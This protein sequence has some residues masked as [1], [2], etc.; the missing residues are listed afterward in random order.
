MCRERPEPKVY[1]NYTYRPKVNHLGIDLEANEG[2]PAFAAREGRIVKIN[3]GDISNQSIVIRHINEG[4]Q[5]FATRYQHLKEV[6]VTAGQ[7]IE[8]GD[9]LGFIGPIGHLHFEVH[10]IINTSASPNDWNR[11]NM[12]PIGPAPLLYPWEKVYFEQILRDRPRIDDLHPET[13]Q[14][15]GIV[16][17][18][19][20]PM[21]WL[22]QSSKI[23][24]IPLYSLDSGDEQL[25]KLLQ[26]AFTS[27]YRRIGLAI[28]DSHFFRDRKIITG[29]RVFS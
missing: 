2:S 16:S 17:D 28:R 23:Y 19:G 3:S 14:E 5:G 27:N 11:M 15:M 1:K 21:F 8:A 9:L 6:A 26:D 12:E 20:V 29:A 24:S 7:L 4:G 13:V 18:K 25:V 10:V 22:R